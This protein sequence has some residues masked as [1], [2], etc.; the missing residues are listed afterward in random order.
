MN[1]IKRKNKIIGV[2]CFILYLILIVYVLFFAE[3]LGR[4]VVSSDRSY[5]LEFFKEIRR[6]YVYRHSVGM[7]SFL[8]NIFGNIL[9]FVPFGFIQPIIGKRK[10]SF[11]KTMLI[12]VV[13]VFIIELIQYALN[14]GSFDVDD[15]FL[16]TV[17]S[18]LGY[19]IFLIFHKRMSHV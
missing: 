2:I 4:T 1:K 15:I 18:M 5:N 9:I 11:I 16:N 19:I 17:G 13:F 14:V 10:A 12:T 3:S 7:Q 8:M 6:F